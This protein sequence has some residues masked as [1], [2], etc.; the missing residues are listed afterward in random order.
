MSQPYQYL[1]LAAV[2]AR[3]AQSR[4][5]EYWR[6]IEEIDGQLAATTTPSRPAAEPTG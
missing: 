1:D 3:L 6:S 4:G 2:R 5:R